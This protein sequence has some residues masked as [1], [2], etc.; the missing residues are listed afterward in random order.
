MA[1]SRQHLKKRVMLR[2]DSPKVRA[3]RVWIKR[4]NIRKSQRLIVYERY[5]LPIL[6][7]LVAMKR[8]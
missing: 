6:V 8:F 4:R 2:E 1:T 5:E 3:Y 7:E